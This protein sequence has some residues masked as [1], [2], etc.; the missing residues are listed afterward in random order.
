[1]KKMKPVIIFCMSFFVLQGCSDVKQS[2]KIP[3]ITPS[4]NTDSGA[5]ANSGVNT[6][7]GAN[8]NAGI[9]TDFGANTVDVDVN[10]DVQNMDSEQFLYLKQCVKNAGAL[11]NLN[12]RYQKTLKEM[13]SLISEAKSYAA[14]N[15]S[16][17]VRKTITP[18]FEYKINY[19]C[20]N[21]EQLLIEEY[22]KKIQATPVKAQ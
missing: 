11:S 17:N 14:S 5:N 22:N 12:A 3:V 15:V 21:I 13:H 1:M 10:I 2:K 6:N 7:S 9:N 8:A 18:L 19:K 4:F 20:N 16:G